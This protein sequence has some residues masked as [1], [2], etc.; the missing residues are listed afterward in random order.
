MEKEGERKNRI[1]TGEVASEKARSGEGGERS[2]EGEERERMEWKRFYEEGASEHEGRTPL[3][4]FEKN[5][6]GGRATRSRRSE[7]RERARG[8]T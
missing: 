3:S 4:Q 6:K 7:Q 5:L 1:K 8:T 2:N